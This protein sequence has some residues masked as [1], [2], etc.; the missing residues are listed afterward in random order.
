MLLAVYLFVCG[1]TCLACLRMFGLTIGCWLM[2]LCLWVDY[3]FVGLLLWFAFV[4]LV[5]IVLFGV[6]GCFRD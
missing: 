3:C 4:V 5:L 1:S 6:F 2:P